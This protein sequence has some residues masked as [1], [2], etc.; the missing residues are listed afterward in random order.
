MPTP[1]ERRNWGD[2]YIG[3]ELAAQA[4]YAFRPLVSQSP[5]EMVLGPGWIQGS[6]DIWEDIGSF[7]QQLLPSAWAPTVWT[8]LDSV[9]VAPLRAWI[10]SSAPWGGRWLIDQSIGYGLSIVANW[11]D[12]VIGWVTNLWT[13]FVYKITQLP[14]QVAAAF[15]EWY[16]YGQAQ[17]ERLSSW[18]NLSVWPAIVT[19]IDFFTGLPEG[20][21][22]TLVSGFQA[23]LGQL[24]LLLTWWTAE[25]WPALSSV[26]SFIGELPLQ[27]WSD[28]LGWFTWTNEQ[29]ERLATWWATII[30]PDSPSI[31]GVAL[32]A[33]ADW[34]LDVWG[35]FETGWDRIVDVAGD[36]AMKVID[37]LSPTVREWIAGFETLPE[38]FLTYVAEVAGTDLAMEPS[39]ALETVGSLYSTALAAGSAAHVLST[40]LNAV[41]TLNWVGASQLSAFIAQAAGFDVLT[42][43]TYG[44]LIDDALTWPLR[45]HWN[46][47]LRPRIP[48]EGAVFLMG[49]KRG[50]SRDEFGEAM[51]YH[52]L[53]DWWIDK[54][55]QFFWTDPSPYWLL[56]MSEHA[57]PEIKPSALF[58]PWLDEWLPG[59]R[60]DPWAWFKMKLM[61]AGFE[62]TDIPAFIEGFQQR[63]LGPARTQVKTSVRAMVR[64]AY[65]GKREAE[66]ALRPLGIRDDELEYMMLAEEIDYQNRFNDDQVR[67]YTESYRKAEISRQ[68][69]TMALSTMI[70]KP[71]R[72]AQIVAREDTRKLPKP[73]PLVEA[74]ED[75]LTK[76]L[77]RSA[78]T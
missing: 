43:A 17:I 48:T 56:R 13:P 36:S 18:W 38:T 58:L 39:R 19:V 46:Q 61:L 68:D 3:L 15:L 63:R 6:P 66:A 28:F 70:V 53:P 29:I 62:Q 2:S 20:V 27:L 23:V 76:S 67:Y 7:L 30:S 55:Y 47:L 59:W 78:V 60:E 40:A 65:W 26:M 32:T 1:E 37:R 24:E 75:P 5:L 54:E 33:L 14:A 8:W 34:W 12:V 74:A 57:T 10:T 69:F 9:I 64:E 21:W 49:R 52:G 73:K 25:A 51:A 4:A 45:Y 71:E 42:K 77:V 72:I 22:T 31:F 11:V 41:P 44:T 16:G 50:L 35:D